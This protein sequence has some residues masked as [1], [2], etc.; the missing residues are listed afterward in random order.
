MLEFSPPRGG[1]ESEE[2]EVSRPHDNTAILEEEDFDEEGTVDAEMDV[3]QSEAL[4]FHADRV[5][6]EQHAEASPSPFDNKPELS[7]YYP[8]ANAS[9]AYYPDP[10]QSLTFAEQL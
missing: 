8:D 3:E 6:E 2:Q 7:G 1:G 5:R 10:S 9:S 4:K